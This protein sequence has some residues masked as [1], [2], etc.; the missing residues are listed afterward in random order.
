[1][2]NKRVKTNTE[3]VVNGKLEGLTY[4]SENVVDLI[5]NKALQSDLKAYLKTESDGQKAAWK[6]VRLL[7]KMAGEIKQDFG[8]DYAFA[9]FMGMSQS[10]V[11]KRKRLAE[12]AIELEKCGYTDSKAY[13]LLPLIKKLEKIEIHEKRLD[14]FRQILEMLSPDMTQKEL[15]EA[16]KNIDIEVE[17]DKLIAI[18]NKNPDGDEGENEIIEDSKESNSND[19]DTDSDETI[20][21]C[22][23]GQL[24]NVTIP[25]LV[26]LN[27]EGVLSFKYAEY[28]ISYDILGKILDAIEEIF[29]E[30]E[31]E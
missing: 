23:N 19:K 15:R 10:V 21:S 3:I 18:E 20:Y 7:G 31:A 13:E 16:I 25:E 29:A 24:I 6:L 14:A 11:N 22:E 28:S 17:A 2:A 12:F 4:T 1:M 9:D 26:D 8:S 30:T 27:S 5:N